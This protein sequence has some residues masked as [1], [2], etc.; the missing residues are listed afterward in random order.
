MFTDKG[1]YRIFDNNHVNL[2]NRL[3]KVQPLMPCFKSDIHHVV[4]AF[5]L[6]TKQDLLKINLFLSDNT[7]FTFDL[8]NFYLT[9]L[10]K[11]A[12]KNIEIPAKE[13]IAMVLDTN[14]E[15]INKK[16]ISH[17]IIVKEKPVIEAG[18]GDDSEG[19]IVEKE[20]PVKEEKEG[21]EQIS[22][23]DDLDD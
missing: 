16:T 8:D 21:F 12:K 23:F 20:Q 1:H 19:E 4:S 22:I 13:K 18:E 11:Y 6:T 7:Y 5:K 3:G 17:P 15:I 10:D 14:I 9:D 2:T